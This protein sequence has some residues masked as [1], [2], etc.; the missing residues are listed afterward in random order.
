[1]VLRTLFCSL[2]NV[3]RAICTRSLTNKFVASLH[4]IIWTAEFLQIEPPHLSKQILLASFTSTDVV[5]RTSFCFSQNVHG[6]ICTRSLTSELVDSRRLII[7]FDR[8]EAICFVFFEDVNVD[9]RGDFG[10]EGTNFMWNG[11]EEWNVRFAN[12]KWRQSRLEM[13][14]SAYREIKWI[15]MHRSAFHSR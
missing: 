12:L 14:C 4:L 13:I 9:I 10:H 7:V 1:M 11:R 3:R 5:L 15:L 6:A 2:Q 8:S